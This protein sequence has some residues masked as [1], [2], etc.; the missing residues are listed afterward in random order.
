VGFG[1][2]PQQRETRE[3]L[4]LSNGEACLALQLIFDD[5]LDSVQT[6]SQIRWVNFQGEPVF[7]GGEGAVNDHLLNTVM[8]GRTLIS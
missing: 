5:L 4:V 8:T 6:H 7:V 3:I 2:L 1:K